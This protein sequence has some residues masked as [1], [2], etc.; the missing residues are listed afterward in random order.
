MAN[1]ELSQKW[2]DQVDE[3]T[4][5]TLT[6]DE[7]IKLVKDYKRVISSRFSSE[8]KV[9]LFGSYS[10]DYSK[11]WSDID[12][13]VILPSIKDEDWL[14]QSA[15]LWHDVDKVSLLI[16]PVLLSAE[17]DTLL[18]REVIRNGIAVYIYNTITIKHEQEKQKD[19]MAVVCAG[20]RAVADSLRR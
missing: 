8:P 5:K 10:K 11:T 16:E 9:Y 13:A 12:V 14:E 2:L 7:A 6:R 18:Y 4:P 3:D 15:D 17:E 20:C 19:F 1:K